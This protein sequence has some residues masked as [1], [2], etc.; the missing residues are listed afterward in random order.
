MDRFRDA[1]GRLLTPPERLQH[2][3][4]VRLLRELA[5]RLQAADDLAQQW[6]GRGIGA[7][8]R[9]GGDL[10][11]VLAVRPPA[12][13]RAT[14][15]ALVRREAVDRLL[16]RLAH[17]C[18]GDRQALRAL[19]GEAEIP[20]G[21]VDLVSELRALRAPKSAAAISRARARVSRDTSGRGNN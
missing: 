10:A 13:S 14:P 5:G 20:A 12:G 1:F 21:A 4:R 9:Q 3:E 19:R 15:Q 2:A 18:D 8:L 16:L 11:A 17:A 6:L 7:W